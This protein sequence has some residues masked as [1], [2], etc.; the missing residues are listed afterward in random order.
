[1][2]CS[3]FLGCYSLYIFIVSILAFR[4][5]LKCH[6]LR[7]AIPDHSPLVS[8]IL[9]IFY[10]ALNKHLLCTYYALGIALRVL[11]IATHLN[12][13]PTTC[14]LLYYY[15]PS[16]MKKMK[17][18]EIKLLA[19]GLISGTCHG[20]DYHWGEGIGVYDFQRP[21]LVG[22]N[23]EETLSAKQWSGLMCPGLERVLRSTGWPFSR[24]VFISKMRTLDL[25]TSLAFQP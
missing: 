24:R 12:F 15:P 21:C 2:C 23:S 7:E 4:F 1:M 6:L 10:I 18:K 17:H 3:F 16:K 11:Q 14:Y 5:Q 19:Q 9:F 20:Q 13:P 8:F 25:M 22:D